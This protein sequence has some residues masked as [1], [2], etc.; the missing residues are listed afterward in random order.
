[1]SCAEG[2]DRKKA[3]G[4]VEKRA[5][6]VHMKAGHGLSERRACVRSG[7]TLAVCLSIS[8]E[9][10]KRPRGAAGV[11]GACR[12][13]SGDGFRKVLPDASTDGEGLES[14]AGLP[15]LLRDEAKQP[16]KT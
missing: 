7:K 12:T 8:A 16:S 13:S 2:R 6:V 3:L 14:Q 4:T 9:A 5:A 10:E 15:R 1:M 11:N